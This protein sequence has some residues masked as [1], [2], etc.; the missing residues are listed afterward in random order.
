VRTL[1]KVYDPAKIRKNREFSHTTVIPPCFIYTTSPRS[2]SL[3]YK[4][5]LY[6]YITYKEVASVL[7]I[8]AGLWIRFRQ[9]RFEQLEM[10]L[11]SFLGKL[12]ILGFRLSFTIWP[13]FKHR[14][15][16]D[17]HM[18]CKSTSWHSL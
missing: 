3:S 13:R 9:T 8:F 17:F 2:R 16:F 14:M 11:L 1:P 6:S 5:L 18:P 4:P 10:E 15:G 12:S 7:G